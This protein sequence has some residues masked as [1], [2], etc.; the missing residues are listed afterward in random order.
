MLKSMQ[1]KRKQ[2]KDLQTDLEVINPIES[3]KILGGDWYTDRWADGRSDGNG[4][5]ILTFHE[6]SGGNW[7]SGA[8]TFGGTYDPFYDGSYTSDWYNYGNQEAGGGGGYNGQDQIQWDTDGFFD[9][10]NNGNGEEV[11]LDSIGLKDNVINSDVY[12]QMMTNVNNQIENFVHNQVKLGSNAPGTY[13]FSWDFNNSY[14]FT[15]VK[16]LFPIGAATIDG[17][18]LGSFTIDGNGN[19]NVNGTLDLN[20]HD[21][22]EDP[23]DLFNLVPGSWDPSGDPY[24]INGNWQQEILME[25]IKP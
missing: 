20:F 12:L 15:L 17:K 11:D 19:I 7:A 4:G 2:I 22:F 10:Y 25:N 3:K 5:M 23:W 8:G 16:D 9:H 18:F 6:G 21:R 24:D 1:K 13:Q 14:D